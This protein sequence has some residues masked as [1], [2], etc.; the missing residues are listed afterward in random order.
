M[1]YWD[2]RIVNSE[3]NPPLELTNEEKA[4]LVA[5]FFA[6]REKKYPPGTYGTYGHKGDDKGDGGQRAPADGKSPRLAAPQE[7]WPGPPMAGE[8]SV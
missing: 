8:P 4:Q 3:T 5:D 6:E 2:E 1:C 7:T